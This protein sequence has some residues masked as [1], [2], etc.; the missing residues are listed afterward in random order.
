MGSGASTEVPSPQAVASSRRK[1]LSRGQTAHFSRARQTGN[2]NT[3]EFNSACL[4]VFKNADKDSNGFVSEPEFWAVIQSHTL[5]LNLSVKEFKDL[6]REAKNAGWMDDPRGLNYEKFIPLLKLL[7]QRVYSRVTDSSND[8][9]LITN[10]GE[11]FQPIYM[12]KRTGET[13]SEPPAGFQAQMNQ[14]SFEYFTLPDGTL[15]TTYVADDGARFYVDFETNQE[16]LPFPQEWESIIKPVES[17]SEEA[18]ESGM[19]IDDPRLSEYT[20]PTFGPMYIYLMENSRNTYLYMDSESGEWH[21][22]PLA[23]ERSV[24][25]VS[26]MLQELDNIFPEWGNVQEQLLVLREC[27]YDISEAIAFADLNWNFSGQADINT[28]T[29]AQLMRSGT[30]IS[31]AR[32]RRDR[33]KSSGT[34]QHGTSLSTSA[35]QRIDELERVVARQKRQI[36]KLKSANMEEEASAVKELVREKT[37]VATQVQRKA[38]EAMEAQELIEDI[39]FECEKWRSRSMD[40]EEQ[41]VALK[42]D[43]DHYKMLAGDAQSLNNGESVGVGLLQ[44][45]DEQ[46]EKV[47][48]ENV[49]LKLK[50]KDLK[51]QLSHPSKSTETVKYLQRLHAKVRAAKREKDEAVVELQANVADLARMFQTSIQTAKALNTDVARRIK[52]ITSKY[53]KEQMERK[54]LYNKVQELR[55]NIRVFMRV[56]KD[57]RGES[58]FKFPSE[59]ECIVKTT[60]GGEQLFDF[61]RC[62]G[63]DTKQDTVFEDTKPVILSCVDGYNVCILAYGQTGSGKTFTMM[64]PTSQPGVNRRAIKE[65]LQLCNSR[66]EVDYT[67]GVSM[68]EV[69]NEK[70][71]DLLSSD[72]GKKL[73]VH[74]GPQGTY[75]GDLL[76]VEVSSQ[77]EIE[78]IM[79][80]G[81]KNRSVACTKMN[82]DS[83]RSHLLFQIKVSGFNKISHTTTTGKLTLVDLAGSERVSKTDASGERLLEAA[84]INKSLSALGQV[85]Q[86]LAA[87]S[88]HIPYRNSKLTHALKDSLG[89]DSKT[90][91]FVNVSPLESNLAE[92]HCTLLFGSNIRKIELGPASKHTATSG[93]SGA[94][95]QPKLPKGKA[96]PSLAGVKGRR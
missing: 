87:N 50:V 53:L 95:P 9:C 81:D 4:A 71:F 84:A 70:I 51:D 10:G 29:P 25:D 94:K 27:N 40:L 92:T 30:L 60:S 47:R 77:R 75:V 72:R 61:D 96:P 18:D 63:T 68:M 5:N 13:Q 91:V 2:Y 1:R 45:R 3:D 82:T 23:W 74:S 28:E 42:A 17:S 73:N 49:A 62:Y 46:L 16:W 22:M 57:T 76:E 20:H 44:R 48:M 52:E 19:P 39:E 11:E 93:G 15:I 55:G 64:G 83:S 78:E 38:R 21:R 31:S 67:I 65:L 34:S 80:K 79:M 88:P 36:A 33:R 85:F 54:L 37:R 14:M 12:N 7:L 86:A 6:K 66:E 41:L 90:C 35:A 32:S 56:R 69:Y 89:G 43:L 59:T 26:S 24:P 58:V 8:W